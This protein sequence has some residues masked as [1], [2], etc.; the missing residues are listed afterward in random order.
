MHGFVFAGANFELFLRE[1]IFVGLDILKILRG[2]IFAV[3]KYV[4]LFCVEKEEKSSKLAKLD[5]S[6]YRNLITVV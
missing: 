2:F 1:F 3:A 6:Y 5:Q 4:I